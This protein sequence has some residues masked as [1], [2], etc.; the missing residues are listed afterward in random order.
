M[1]TIADNIAEIRN[2]IEIARK[3]SPC[4]EQEITLVA[5]TKMHSAE[6]IHQVVAAGQTLWEKIVCRS[7]LT[8]MRL[9]VKVQHGTLLGICKVIR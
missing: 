3:K 5:V 9:W 7:C 2:N 8:S 1:R 6:E 4:P